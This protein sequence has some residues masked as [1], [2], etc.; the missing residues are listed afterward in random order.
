MLQTLIAAGHPLPAVMGY[1]LEQVR[2]WHAA[3]QRAEARRL[4]DAIIAARSTWAD[5]DALKDMLSRLT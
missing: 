2:W 5:A 1:T 4:V 3:C